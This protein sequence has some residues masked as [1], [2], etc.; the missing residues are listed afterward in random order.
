MFPVVSGADA[1]KQHV[2]FRDRVHKM[3]LWVAVVL[4]AVAGCAAPQQ[5]IRRSDP[6]RSLLTRSDSVYIAVPRDA[7]YKGRTYLDSGQKTSDALLSL[8][9][10]RNMKA[11]KANSYQAFED[12][13]RTARDKAYKYLFYPTIVR[14]EDRESEWSG[15][16]DQVEIEVEIVEASTGKVLDSAILRRKSDIVGSG[17]GRPQELLSSLFSDYVHNLFDTR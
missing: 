13:T 17:L 16:T 7:V 6:E 8:F 15:K 14:W 10:I 4:T 1:A 12:A 5:E 3:K 9:L 2:T 11:E